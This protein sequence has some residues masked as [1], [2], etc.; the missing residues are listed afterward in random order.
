M[1]RESQDPPALGTGGSGAEPG[2]KDFPAVP[3]KNEHFHATC[4]INNYEDPNEVRNCE[5]DRLK[6]LDQVGS[7]FSKI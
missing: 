1:S 2:Q 7:I 4:A 5:L 3:Y 6:D